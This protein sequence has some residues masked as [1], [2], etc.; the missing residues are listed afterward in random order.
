[1][2]NKQKM[3]ERERESGKERRRSTLRGGVFFFLSRIFILFEQ[4][5]EM[6]SE[7]EEKGDADTLTF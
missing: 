2:K 3:R 6:N 5:I 7:I 1:M 4:K